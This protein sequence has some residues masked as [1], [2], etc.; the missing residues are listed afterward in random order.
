M[1][2]Y[3]SALAELHRAPHPMFVSERK[4]LAEKLVAEGDKAGAALLAKLVRPSISAWTVNQLYWQK[5]DDFGEFLETAARVRR[6]DL[7]ATLSHRKMATKLVSHAKL[8]LEGAGHAPSEVTLRRVTAT[9]AA[10]AAAGGFEPD[11]PGTLNSDRDPPGFDAVGIENL[12]AKQ[13]APRRNG[14]GQDRQAEARR[15]SAGEAAEKRRAAEEQARAKVE[16]RRLEGLL[17]TAQAEV[18]KLTRERDD[19]KR[20]FEQAEQR[21]ERARDAVREFEARLGP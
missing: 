11:A 18:E 14:D 1:S 16:R 15:A 12:P 3:D 21:L 9:L 5:R 7:D 4:R 20:D 8:I 2:L 13:Q 17:R 19:K 10:L 6:G